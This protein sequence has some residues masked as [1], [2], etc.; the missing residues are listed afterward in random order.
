MREQNKS[1]TALTR[2]YGIHMDDRDESCL[3][4]ELF[5]HTIFDIYFVFV[6][7]AQLSSQS[8]IPSDQFC[9]LLEFYFQLQLSLWSDPIAFS[10]PKSIWW[11]L[12]KIQE[13]GNLAETQ[14]K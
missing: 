10:A 4:A 14:M 6:W 13:D 11:L 7:P 9:S 12:V 1:S 5:Y 2:N 8:L 3:Y